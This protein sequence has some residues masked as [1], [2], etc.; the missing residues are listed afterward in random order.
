VADQTAEKYT[1]THL[2]QTRRLTNCSARVIAHI[3]A[4]PLS[5]EVRLQQRVD[6]GVRVCILWP[7]YCHW[8]VLDH[9]LHC[10]LLAGA[11][12]QSVKLAGGCHDLQQTLDLW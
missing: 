10:I 12:W 7:V 3:A 6:L 4:E 11:H 9:A 5:A 1:K 8:S 2:Q